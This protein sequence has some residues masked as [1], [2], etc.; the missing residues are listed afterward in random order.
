MPIESSRRISGPIPTAAPAALQ[1]AGLSNSLGRCWK[2]SKSSNIL[3]NETDAVTCQITPVASP[4]L[5]GAVVE[6]RSL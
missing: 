2:R 1:R 4:C 5:G 3:I 6:S